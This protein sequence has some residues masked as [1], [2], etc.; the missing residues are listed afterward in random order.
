MNVIP[1]IIV[2][3]VHIEGPLKGEI[4]EFSSLEILIGRH[5]DCQVQFP[6]DAVTLSRKHARIVR[7]GNRFKL[8]DQSTNGTF[9]N[10]QQLSEAYLKQGDV[11]TFS[12]GGPKVSFLTQTS[13]QPVPPP[14]MAQTAE[15]TEPAATTPPVRTAV[16]PQPSPAFQHEVQPMPEAPTPP[17]Q[18]S[19]TAAAP[20]ANAQK[21]TISFAVQYG[22]T[23]KSFQSLPITLGK[24]AH[25]DF[26]VNHPTLFDQQAQILFSQDQYWVKDLTGINA[27]LIDGMPISGI[28]ALQPDMQLSLSPQGPKFRFLGGGR[29]VEVE[30]SLPEAPSPAPQAKP[31]PSIV[32]G[33][34]FDAITKKA[35]SLWDFLSNLKV[36]RFLGL[37]R[38]RSNISTD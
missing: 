21:M 34:K 9:V 19:S 36:A 32:P 7:E 24:G 16:P 1:N 12:E 26:I 14:Q 22:P 15:P 3:L 35:E 28:A 25:C 30:E 38:N 31:M 2:Q 6:K 17:P 8:V 5:P 29:L 13:D 10:G 27:V 20:L 18:S 23:L 33:N 11:I 37:D 4:Q